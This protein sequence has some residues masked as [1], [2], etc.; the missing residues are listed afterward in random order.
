MFINTSRGTLLITIDLL[1]F[2]ENPFEICGVGGEVSGKFL[3][4]PVRL[5]GSPSVKNDI[6]TRQLKFFMYAT[7]M[8]IKSVLFY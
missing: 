4:T 8:V 2:R 1:T 6:V 5:R 3:K 7:G